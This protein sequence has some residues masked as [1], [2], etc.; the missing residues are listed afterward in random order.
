MKIWNAGSRFFALKAEANNHRRELGIKPSE[1]RQLNVAGRDDLCDLLNGLIAPNQQP[2]ADA[3]TEQ[4]VAA[5]VQA[6]AEIV[7]SYVPQFLLNAEQRRAR[8]SQKETKQ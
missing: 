6:D 5:T 3:T 2:A 8:L 7:P 4:Q 1:L